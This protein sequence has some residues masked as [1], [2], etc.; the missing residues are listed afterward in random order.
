MPHPDMKPFSAD[1][2][3]IRER[4]ALWLAQRDAGFA[5]GQAEEFARWR[6]ADPRHAEA[7][8]TMEATRHLL[9]RLPESPAAAALL[10]EV[11]ALCAARTSARPARRV[12]SFHPWLKAVAGLAAVAAGLALFFLLPLG[13][14]D[15]DATYATAAGQHRSLDL[16]DGSTLV[17]ADNSEVHVAFT[18]GERRVLL[19]RGETHF[20][21]AKNPARPFLVTAGPVTVRAVGTA[22]NVRRD[23]AAVEVLVTEGKVQISRAPDTA[24]AS[25]PAEPIY[26]VA[27]ERALIDHLGSSPLL[28]TG[29]AAGPL[30]AASPWQAPRLA[31]NNTP[32]AEVVAQ[33]NRYNRV[34]MEIADT[35]LSRLPVG[36]NFNA[37]N[38]ESFIN[39]LEAGGSVRVERLA[40]YRVLLHKTP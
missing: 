21:V 19:R 2:A 20:Y 39:L 36:G 22:F 27:G 33:F 12:V 17:L 18:A 34:Q 29:S 24:A 31:F 28:A 9:A 5:P 26:L 38:A 3:A 16:S 13:A 14:R 25:S 35:A 10:A 8:A 37:N 1:D 11:D 23:A 6:D 30:E 4:A 15:A 40:D 32:L 7:L